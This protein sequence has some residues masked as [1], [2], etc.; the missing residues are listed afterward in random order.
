MRKP[1]P[2]RGGRHGLQPQ[3]LGAFTD[4]QVL[5]NVGE[6]KFAF[7]PCVAGIYNAVDLLALCLPFDNVEQFGTPFAGRLVRDFLLAKA[8]LGTVASGRLQLE[9]FRQDGKGFQPPEPIFFL[10]QILGHA[11]LH[12]VARGGADDHIIPVED[13]AAC[14]EASQ[15][16]GDVAGD[17]WLFG[18]DKLFGHR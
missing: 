3:A 10:V 4:P 1:F 12:K 18:Y 5:H 8:A 15:G 7:A 16:F 11:K 6:D 17:G 2:D 14:L 13:L 9:G